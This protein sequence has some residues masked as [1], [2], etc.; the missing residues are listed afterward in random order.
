MTDNIR[1][2]LTW[3]IIERYEPKD[4]HVFRLRQHKARHPLTGGDHTFTIVDTPDWVNVI[5]LTADDDVVMVRQFRHGT[6][7]VSLE[8]PGGLVEPGE[9][10]LD[11][12][13]RELLEETGYVADDWRF[14]G[15]VEP[16]PAIQ[17][18]RCDL[19]L[20]LDARRVADLELDPTEVIEVDRLPLREV[21]AMMWAGE[22]THALVVAAFAFLVTLA[23]GW[24]RPERKNHSNTKEI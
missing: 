17:S 20:A 24:R 15:Y 18:N 5:A 6:E 19:F 7:H 9:Q 10:A 1:D 22:I 13:R 3:P 16:N 4:Y 2:R 12:A 23:G 8:I 11:A 21:E 14:L